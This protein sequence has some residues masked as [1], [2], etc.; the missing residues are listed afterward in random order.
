MHEPLESPDLAQL[1]GL[2]YPQRSDLG[3]FTRVVADEIPQPYRRLLAHNEHMT[4]TVEAFHQSPVNVQVLATHWDQNY[5]SRKIVLTRQT[6]G[7]P[8]QFGIPRLNVSY[9]AEPVRREIEAE[10]TPLGRVLIQ[11]NVLRCVQLVALWKVLPG[12]DL[13]AMF[14]LSQPRPT[15][16]RTAL[17]YCDGE[18]AIELLEIV[19]PQ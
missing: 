6:D 13:C 16:G 9:L 5:Y 12:P 8:V 11:H 1:V 19:A 2:F 18:P 4:V 3:E 14:R 17:I 10:Q 7:L 15:F